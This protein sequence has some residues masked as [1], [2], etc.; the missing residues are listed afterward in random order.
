MVN[1]ICLRLGRIK[2]SILLAV[3]RIKVVE[4]RLPYNYYVNLFLSAIIANFYLA[5]MKTRKPAD[6]SLNSVVFA[7]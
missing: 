1:M 7:F 4:K 2:Y 6:S 3:Q 5:T